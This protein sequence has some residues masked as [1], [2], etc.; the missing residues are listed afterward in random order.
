M[1]SDLNYTLLNINIICVYIQ[2][3][4]LYFTGFAAITGKSFHIVQENDHSLY[5]DPQ[6]TKV[7]SVD[8]M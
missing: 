4:C 5:S 6:N 8:R 7:H 2:E 3:L 1:K